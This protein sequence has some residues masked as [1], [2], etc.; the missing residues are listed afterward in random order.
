MSI[1]PMNELRPRINWIVSFIIK[2][3][4]GRRWKKL[5][6]NSVNSL[7]DLD[8]QPITSFSVAHHKIQIQKDQNFKISTAVV[9]WVQRLSNDQ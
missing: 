7:R 2:L 3:G 4:G 5:W 8:A 6:L 9:S 1:T